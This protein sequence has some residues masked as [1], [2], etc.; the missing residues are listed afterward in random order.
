MEG[1][2]LGLIMGIIIPKAQEAQEVR[3]EEHKEHQLVQI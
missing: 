1:L 2:E 3:E